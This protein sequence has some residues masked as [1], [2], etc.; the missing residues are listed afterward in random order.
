MPLKPEQVSAALKCGTNQKLSDGRGLYLVVKNGRGFW[1]HQFWSFGPTQNNPVP[2]GH[3]R[4][5][6]LGTVADLTPAAAR[7]ERDAYAVALREGREVGTRKGRSESFGT[8]AAAYLDNHA[9]EWSPRHRAGFKSLVRKHVPEDFAAKPAEHI[10]SD[11]VAAVLKPIW[12]GPGNNRGSRLRRLIEGI[13]TA[14]NV[15][16]NPARWN[17]PLRELLSRKRAAVTPR[18]AM[19]ASD[20]PAFY[21]TLGDDVE[22]RAMRLVILTGVR[23]KEALACR[24]SEFDLANSVWVI[25]AERTKMR[26]TH[27]VPLTEEMIACLG[28]RGAHD[29]LL[30]PSKRTGGLMGNEALK[31]KDHGYTLHGFRS[32]LGTWAEE[33]D[34]GRLYPK[35]VIDAVLAHG[36]ENAV[37]AAYLR[38]D[39]FN[40]RR[41]LMEHWCRYVTGKARP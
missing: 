18:A 39:Q 30:F 34:D 20:L 37:D 29:A 5:K 40:A 6:C 23:R 16:P 4:S 33:Q 8:A 10:T 19:P 11:D 14:R 38:S 21:A 24:W 41:K 32:T 22:A 3:T 1:V 7:R 25:P 15:H 27:A 2:H 35:R 13:L 17:G 26:R 9:D 36:R 12:N 28:E 31:M